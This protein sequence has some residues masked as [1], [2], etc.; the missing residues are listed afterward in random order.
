[1]PVS[2]EVTLVCDLCSTVIDAARSASEVLANAKRDRASDRIRVDDKLYDV[3]R[4]CV[5][6]H[7][8]TNRVRTII[9]THPAASP[10]RV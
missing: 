1:M 8:G 4:G 6:D 2:L 9:R 7:G 3:C 5:R 10:G